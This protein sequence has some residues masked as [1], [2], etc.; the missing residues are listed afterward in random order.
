[1]EILGRESSMAG[2]YDLMDIVA[3]KVIERSNIP[4]R[5]LRSDVTNIKNAINGK[6]SIGTQI[7][8]VK[9]QF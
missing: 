7:V 4:T 9:K 2:T 3:L 6:Y 5:V 8:V 1:M